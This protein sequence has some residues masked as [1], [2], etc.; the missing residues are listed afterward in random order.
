MNMEIKLIRHGKTLIIRGEAMAG[1]MTDAEFGA[2][3]LDAEM[4]IN[5]SM[6]MRCHINA[7]GEKPKSLLMENMGRAMQS[8]GLH[9]ADEEA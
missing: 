3:L 9:R 5:L 1:G 4:A 7:A 6:D 2:L 8:L